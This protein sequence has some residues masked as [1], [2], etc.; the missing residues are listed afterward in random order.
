MKRSDFFGER[1]LE[2]MLDL[3][4]YLRGGVAPI[5]WDEESA[6]SLANQASD[7]VQLAMELAYYGGVDSLDVVLNGMEYFAIS[8]G[9]EDVRFAIYILHMVE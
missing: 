6:E 4:D 5:D 9:H 3:V 1:N 7:L 2:E 8:M